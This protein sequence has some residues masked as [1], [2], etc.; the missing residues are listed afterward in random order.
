MTS[1]KF[2]LFFFTIS[3]L[4]GCSRNQSEDQIPPSLYEEPEISVLPTIDTGGYSQKPIINSSGDTVITGQ[5]IT[6]QPLVISKD[7]LEEP[8]IVPFT[9]NQ[10]TKNAHPETQLFPVPISSNPINFDQLQQVKLG[11]GNQKFHLLNL[12]GDTLPTNVKIP[13]VKSEFP[14]SVQV[15]DGPQLQSKLNSTYNLLFSE[16]DENLPFNYFTSGF[17]DSKN[18]FWFTTKQGLVKYNGIEFQLITNSERDLQ[19]TWSVTEDKQGNIWYGSAFGGLTKYDGE[20]LTVYSIKKE[21]PFEL[22]MGLMA[23]SKGNI[24]FKDN[25]KG[26]C[27]FD[28]EY[29]TYFTEKEGLPSSSITCTKED[30]EGNIWFGTG[31]H[32]VVKFSGSTFV[33]ISE[34]DGLSGNYISDIEEDRKGNIWFGTKNKGLSIFDGKFMKQYYTEDG[35]MNQ[36]EQILLDEDGAIWI[37]N[38]SSQIYS[39]SDSLITQHN[40]KDDQFARKVRSISQD[41][42]GNIWFTGGIIAKHCPNKFTNISKKDGLIDG[43]INSI[44]EDNNGNYWFS[45]QSLGVTFYNGSTY[46]NVNQTSGLSTDHIISLSKDKAGNIWFATLSGGACSFDGENFFHYGLAQGI[47]SPVVMK[48]L[49]SENEDLWF[50]TM[51][52]GITRFDGENYYRYNDLNSLSSNNI[53]SILEDSQNNLWFA[54]MGGGVSKY[55]NGQ[56]IHYTENE[57]LLSNNVRALLE[58]QNGNLWIGTDKGISK[59]NG[60][61]FTHF[62]MDQGLSGNTIQSLIE[63]SNGN[64]WVGG[65]FGL[66]V[67]TTQIR[68]DQMTSN[69]DTI[70]YQIRSYRKSDGLITNSFQM[71]AAYLDSKNTLWWG[72]SE[73]VTKLDLNSFSLEN[74]TPT[75]TLNKIAINEQEFNP[76]TAKHSDL[77]DTYENVNVFDYYPLNLVLPYDKNHLTF[78]FS[79]LDWNAPE[80]IRYSFRLKGL[81][82]NWSE[83]KQETK[84][85]FRSLPYGDF[86]FELKAIGASKNWSKSFLYTFTILP[87]WWHT[88]WARILFTLFGVSLI[89][90]FIRRRTKK[91][92][93]RQAELEIEV[94][95]ATKEILEQKEIVEEAHKEITDSINYAERIQ[96]SFLATEELLNENLGEHFVYFNPKEAV[97]GDFYWAG[98]LDNGNFAVSCADSTG[99]GVPGAI[100]SILNISSIEKAVENKLCK[101]AEIFNKARQLIIERLKKDGSSE[102]GKDGMDASLI[103]LNPDKTVMQYVAAHNP[104]WII[105][106]GELIEIKAEKMPVGKHDHDHIPFEGGEIE[107]QKGDIIYTLTDGYQDQFGGEKG[108]K[109]KVKPF[110]RLLL[111]NWELPMLEQHQKISDTFDE[112]K[113]D[114]EQ[115]DDVCVVG[116]RI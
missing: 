103:S 82:N 113:G 104:I 59:L 65:S 8:K 29:L 45:T 17:N 53:W 93:K 105:R 92:K 9:P 72:N 89:W 85:D 50:A 14:A 86:T 97:S 39:V 44:I 115:V 112:W 12:I 91:L 63:D 18:N 108:K 57:G 25:F 75:P 106:S 16:I 116:V 49:V 3:I 24:W 2:Y 60:E 36:V 52:G 7:I 78:S 13:L 23:D 28:G 107:L 80:Q 68:K 111:E 4:A 96:R 55:Y 27:L 26:I 64:I 66:N 69:T 101:P 37:L 84:A 87:P 79:A 71:N 31:N 102:G 77:I 42:Q 20:K 51:G 34:K 114:L 70:S 30:S 33:N 109:Y 22:C 35:S 74:Q 67:I 90:L 73:G 54:T 56:F 48:V 5:A 41:K 32:G 81:N 21:R 43:N 100:M 11:D 15:F 40:R 99:H 95:N 47:P 94:A 98:K 88:W 1:Q 6:S 62:T 83:P 10:I 46:Q 110:K 61:V 76:K 58:D 38:G 19:T